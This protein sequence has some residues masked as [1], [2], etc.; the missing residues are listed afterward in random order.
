[1]VQVEPRVAVGRHKVAAWVA[2]DCE[3]ACGVHAHEVV[4]KGWHAALHVRP[5]AVD[6][7][8]F[9]Q[10]NDL[11]VV[12]PLAG[13]PGRD[14]TLEAARVVAETEERGLLGVGEVAVRVW[15]SAGQSAEHGTQVHAEVLEGPV[16]ETAAAVA[17]GNQDA[18]I[19]IG[20]NTVALLLCAT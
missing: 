9:E 8:A 15:G 19:H 6:A 2:T 11:R 18:R 20:R 3:V 17:V 1:M 4:D 13:R 14:V 16:F 10:R 5:E 7:L 12:G